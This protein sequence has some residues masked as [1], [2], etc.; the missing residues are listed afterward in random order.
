MG[1]FCWVGGILIMPRF[2]NPHMER[3]YQYA[4]DIKIDNQ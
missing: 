2:R 4:L 3:A 1:A